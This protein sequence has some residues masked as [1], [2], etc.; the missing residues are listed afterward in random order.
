MSRTVIDARQITLRQFLQQIAN[1]A[2]YA[3]TADSKPADQSE[4]DNLLKAIDDE[5]TPLLNLS[6]NS[7]SSL[8]INVGSSVITNSESSRSRSIPHIGALLPNFSAGTITFPASSGGNITCSPGGS[9]V[10]TVSSGNYIKVLVYL[11]GTGALNTLLGIE[12][13]VEANA[14]V[15]PAPKKTFPIGYVTLQNVAGVIQNITQNKVIQFGMG[16]GSGSGSEASGTLIPEGGYKA[17]IED[18]FSVNKTDPTSFISSLSSA[19]YDLVNA[20]YKISCDKSKTITTVGTAYTISSAPSFTM[21]AGDI[22]WDN[23]QRVWRRVSSVT[24]PTTGVLNSA[25]PIDLT[26]AAGMISQ[27]IHSKDFANYGDPAGLTE[28][29]PYSTLLGTINHQA[30]LVDYVDSLASSDAYGDMTSTA[31]IAMVASN[32]GLVTDLISYPNENTYGNLYT[33][34]TFPA[35]INDYGLLSTNSNKERLFLTFFANPDNG[36]VTSSCNLIKYKLSCYPEEIVSKGGVLQSAYC[37]TDSSSTPNQCTNP[38]LVADPVYAATVTQINLS[39]DYIPG[40]NSN[41]PDG[42]LVVIL[43]GAQIPRYYTGIT[44]LSYREIDSRTIRLNSDL[45]ASTFSVHVQK[46]QGSIDTKSENAAKLLAMY[47]AIVG[48]SSQVAIGAATHT[49]ITSAI[50]DISAGQSILVLAGTYTENVTMNKA[51]VIEGQGNASVISG[52]LIVTADYCKFSKMRVTGNVTTNAGADYNDLSIFWTANSTI[53][54]NNGASN[55]I[56]AIQD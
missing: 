49:S 36:A 27:A 19:S 25:F 30:I 39:W 52:N 38:T 6:A 15:P 35:Q 14:T 50:A 22:I 18:S 21:Q 55:I 7:P 32:D 44:G 40:L 33:R 10:L 47:T 48:S 5:L 26:S 3:G 34:P 20:I 12:N 45:S 24:T 42:D 11:D 51:C 1:S 2:S 54:T 8:I 46:R 56:I 37:W 4:L 53:I 28:E 13:A 31:R 16:S 41:K 9:S 43:E 17:A 29:L 23:S